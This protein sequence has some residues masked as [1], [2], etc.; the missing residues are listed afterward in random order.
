MR[1]WRRDLAK[2]KLK[3]FAEDVDEEGARGIY[4]M[5][6]TRKPDHDLASF[7]FYEVTDDPDELDT[8]QMNEGELSKFSA[9]VQNA[10]ESNQPSS[11][12]RLV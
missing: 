6:L 2:G 7:E 10:I 11:M 5:E 1:S 9:F 12:G 3:W 8:T 4:F